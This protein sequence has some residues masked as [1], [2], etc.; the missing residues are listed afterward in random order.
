MAKKEPVMFHLIGQIGSGLAVGVIANLL[1]PGKAS[2]ALLTTA[3]I[4][5]AGSLLGIFAGRV[6]FGLQSDFAEWVVSILGA[7]LGLILYRLGSG[8]RSA[9]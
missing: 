9:Y 4:G 2:G 1:T 8:P 7:S 3:G 6:L 5:L